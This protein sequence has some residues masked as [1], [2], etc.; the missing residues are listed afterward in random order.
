MSTG[1]DYKKIQQIVLAYQN[2]L[3]EL[4]EDR[5]LETPA[6]GG[7]SYSEVYFHIFDSSILSLKQLTC[8]I[9]G[10]GEQKPTAFIV[11]L[12]LF[13]GSLPPGRKYKAPKRLVERLKKISKT[14][15]VALMDDFVKQLEKD[16]LLLPNADKGL[17]MPHPRF[18][19][20]NAFQWLRFIR[21][22]LNH[23]LQQLHRIDQSYLR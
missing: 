6:I 18:G 17:K 9:T 1:K 5:F 4:E 13:M 2:K 12:I 11:K 16:A 10:Q 15:A 14:E 20:L 7:W 8:A 21:I 3:K 19:Y 23:H 22:H